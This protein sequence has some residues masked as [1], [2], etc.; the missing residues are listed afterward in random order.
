[1]AVG[2]VEVRVRMRMVVMRIGRVRVRAMRML[3]SRVARDAVRG[4][5]GPGGGRCGRGRRDPLAL[6][7]MIATRAERHC[8]E[9][10]KQSGGNEARGERARGERA[11]G[12][13]AR[14]EETA[15][16]FFLGGAEAIFFLSAA[17]SSSTFAGPFFLD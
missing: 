3:V 12:N 17:S 4:G 6:L 16:Y 15:H 8:D 1:M 5:L 9:D 10:G 11:H 13:E 2:T 7:V 14:D